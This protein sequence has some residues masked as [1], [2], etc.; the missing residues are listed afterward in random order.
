MR[1][2]ALTR[3]GARWTMAL[4]TSTTRAMAAG[5]FAFRPMEWFTKRIEQHA[6][7]VFE[8]PPRDL[9]DTVST[10]N[11]GIVLGKRVIVSHPVQDRAGHAPIAIPS[12]E[13]PLSGRMRG[14][15]RLDNFEPFEFR[16]ATGERLAFAS[17]LMSD[18]ELFGLGQCRKILLRRPYCMR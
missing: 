11:A 2:L 4:R 12:V 6:K 1:C 14:F 15:D 3:R 8:P 17:V 9:P 18:A 13:H 16:M 7:V 5:S 10:A